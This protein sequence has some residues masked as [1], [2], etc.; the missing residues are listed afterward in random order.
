MPRNNIS[1]E[2]KCM[3]KG[4]KQCT[5]CL[6]MLRSKCSVEVKC[7][8]KCKNDAGQKPLILEVPRQK[9]GQFENGR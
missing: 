7:I 3:D 9:Q 5:V 6:D 1:L 2:R 4:L 8:A